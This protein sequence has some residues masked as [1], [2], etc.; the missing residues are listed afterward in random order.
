MSIRNALPFRHKEAMHI[1]TNEP[2]LS[3]IVYTLDGSREMETADTCQQ[4]PDQK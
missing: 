3:S 1:N 2:N 4:I